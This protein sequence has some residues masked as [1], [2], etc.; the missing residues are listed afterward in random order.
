[1]QRNL[2]I[3]GTCSFLALTTTNT[4]AE[5][6]NTNNELQN[7]K[8]YL[9]LY[10][11]NSSW[12]NTSNNNEIESGTAGYGFGLTY[13]KD[14]FFFLNGFSY[15]LDLSFRYNEIHGVNFGNNILSAD[16]NYLNILNLGINLRYTYN[17]IENIN[18]YVFG[19]PGIS[20]LELTESDPVRK[21]DLKTRILPTLQV[22][23]GI[24]YE[25]SKNW[26]LNFGYRYLTG[27][28]DIKAESED[29][30]L[31]DKYKSNMIYGGI[32]Y[33]F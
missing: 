20:Y 8:Q 6:L 21:F 32:V 22:G 11:G 25:L 30:N 15:E 5:N 27:L 16:G 17:L 1:M 23:A 9:M 12:L 26:D 19:G 31:S 3:L 28:T 7:T 4:H 10:A 24:G 33:K 18:F 13:G 29:K 2:L 14:V